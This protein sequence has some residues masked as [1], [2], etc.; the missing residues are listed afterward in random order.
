M[1]TR[2][3]TA[4]IVLVI[5]SACAVPAPAAAQGLFEAL[6]G[7][8][9]RVAREAPPPPPVTYGY[10]NEE[11]RGSGGFFPFFDS[12]VRSEGGPASAYCVR[13]CDG[14]FFPVNGQAGMSAANACQSF[15]PASPTKLF[16]GSGIDRAVDN[17]G[18]PYA[19]LPNAFV[20]RKKVV[21]G[22]TCNGKTAGGVA[23]LDAASDPT[24]RPGDIVATKSG[25]MA[26]AGGR[27]KT[28][29]FTPV[30]QFRGFG[31]STRDRLA[32]IKIA[33]PSRGATPAAT[34]APAEPP[35]E[36]ARRAENGR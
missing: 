2:R 21:A 8:M 3:T 11:P 7:G 23:A 26:Y 34:F 17:R 29:Q 36:D 15:C 1:G 12:P 31:K 6:F 33:P 20:Y 4:A 25:L 5:A 24:L 22:C 27:D 19:D 13:T 30:N 14:H 10:S 18:S 35:R 32:D 28:A 9:R 16:T